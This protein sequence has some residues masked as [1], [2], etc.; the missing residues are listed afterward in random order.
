MI[1]STITRPTSMAATSSCD[2]KLSLV[3]TVDIGPMTPPKPRTISLEPISRRMRRRR[4]VKSKE[5][6]SQDASSELGSRT[7][8]K[9]TAASPHPDESAS[10][11]GSTD[12]SVNRRSPVPSDILSTVSAATG[13]ESTTSSSSEPSFGLGPAPSSAKSK[14][15]SQCD[16]NSTFADK[17]ITATIELLK[18][19]CLPGDS[20]PLKISI[21]HTKAIKSLHGIIITLYRQGRIDSAPPLSLFV[22]I[23]GKAAEKMKHDE[24][25]PKSKTGLA[26]LSLSSAGSSSLF[27][28]DLSQTFAPIIVDPSTL[29]AVVNASVRV[30]E[31]VFP[32][33]CGVPGDMI[34]FKYH[35]E[36][37]VDLGGKLAGQQ[38]HLPRVGM[39]THPSNYG[40]AGGGRGDVQPNMLATWGG[41][42]VDTD[43][44]R[45][46]KSVVACLFEVIVGTTDSARKRGRGSRSVRREINDWPEEVPVTPST[47]NDPIYEE[48]SRPNDAEDN[49]VEQYPH[50]YHEQSY[51]DRYPN[52]YPNDG[53]NYQQNYDSSNDLY[54]PPSHTQIPVPPPEL[55]EEE[56][57]DEK[58]RVRRAEERLLP[59][60]PPPDLNDVPS[61]SRT[62]IPPSVPS[63]PDEDDL[64][65]AS[66]AMPPP[67]SS[68]TQPPPPSSPFPDALSPSAPALEDLTPHASSTEDKQELERRRLLAEA[69][70]PTDFHA[71]EEDDNAGEGS[72]SSAVQLEPSA[73]ILPEEEEEGGYG[74]SYF[75]HHHHHHT[76]PGEE[77]LPRYER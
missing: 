18:S 59:S 77:I 16:S 67:V 62:I 65:S 29:T 48:P 53:Y 39:V 6:S 7:E 72:S 52:Y 15:G 74:A 61:S 47:R 71:D 69:S 68:T 27:R 58:E 63:I 17:T 34:S 20:L 3:E 70:A 64:Y 40:N 44:V 54:P 25:Y 11:C 45:R 26:G 33:I 4:T 5:S 66:D 49:G 73:P 21:K 28:K 1:T 19:G 42:I 75:H 60:Q 12:H 24:Y 30:P 55:E 13:T 43:Q 22:D 23:K 10:Q 38:R 76:M 51:E 41:S 50:Q 56:G 46:E 37:V 14:R 8:A 32:T 57:L 31:D 9:R 36:V 35:V 2:K